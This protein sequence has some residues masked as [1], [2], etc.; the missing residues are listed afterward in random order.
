M[1]RELLNTVNSTARFSTVSRQKGHQ[2]SRPA[3]PYA[4]QA[5]GMVV[6]NSNCRV[7]RNT[8]FMPRTRVERPP[9][10]WRWCNMSPARESR[11]RSWGMPVEEGSHY[12]EGV[13]CAWSE[14]CMEEKARPGEKLYRSCGAVVEETGVPGHW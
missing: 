10:G 13:V 3:Y 8:W 1:P 12:Y 6:I 4:R 5:H 11:R 2:M 7:A 14:R 9:V